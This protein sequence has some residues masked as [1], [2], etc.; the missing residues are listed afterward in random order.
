MKKHIPVLLD[1][2]ISSLNIKENGIYVDLTLGR[3]GHSLEILKKIQKNNSGMLIC[4]DKDKQAI[5][6]SETKLKEIS[7]SFVLIKS[8]FRF[9]TEKL[10]E[11]NIKKVDGILADLGVSSPQLD[12]IERGF[13]YSKD[14]KLDMR[15]DQDATLDAWQIINHWNEEQLRWIFSN[16]GDVKFPLEI[17]KSVIK[18]RPINSSFE[19]NE[20]I[21]TSLPAWYIRQKNPSKQVFQAIRIAV[22]DELN[23]LDDLL[24]QIPS[25]LNKNGSLAIITFHSKEDFK[26]KKFF[27]DLNYIDPKL[28]KLPIQTQKKWKQKIFFP[29]QNELELNK[30]SRSAKLRVITKLD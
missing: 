30:R 5:T 10:E 29:S 1:E 14:G 6:E 23:A 24:K 9:L 8:D 7:N 15:M 21:K 4:F 13:S 25:L 12:E 11:L 26:V 20:I 28:N 2:V 18:N 22:N 17:A 3:A 27:Q 19:L 16:Y